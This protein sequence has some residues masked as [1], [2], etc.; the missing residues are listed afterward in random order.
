MSI[1]IRVSSEILGLCRSIKATRLHPTFSTAILE[2]TSPI[3]AII[4][5]KHIFLNN[6]AHNPFYSR[7]YPCGK[8]VSL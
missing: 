2:S 7:G 5:E 3:L 4:S 6:E 8:R 1:V